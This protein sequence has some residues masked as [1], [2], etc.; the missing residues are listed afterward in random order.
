MSVVVYA[1]LAYAAIGALV[2]I[3]FAARGAD[4]VLPEP[5]SI[6]FG[7]RL[8]LAPGALLLWPVVLVRWVFAGGSR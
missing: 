4:V 8:L 6:S 5:V 3:A 7:A 2:A 1:V